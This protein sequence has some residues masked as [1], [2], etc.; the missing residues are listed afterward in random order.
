M[1]SPLQFLRRLVSRRGDQKQ[2]TDKAADAKPDLLAIAAPA[3][4]NDE[5]KPAAQPTRL[6]S[7]SQ[8]PSTT[9]SAE[10]AL[11]NE[12]QTESYATTHIVRSDASAVDASRSADDA[13]IAVTKAP[14]AE[15][16]A[17]AV[18]K[19]VRK[20]RSRDENAKLAMGAVQ[21]SHSAQQ[22][23]SEAISLDQEIKALRA[24]LI[25]KLQAQNAHLRKMLARFE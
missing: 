3:E 4:T 12:A 21:S 19:G 25:I 24:Q 18:G 8:D 14:D 17:L 5:D 1:A 15:Q 16:V 13:D 20:R 22:A 6:E 2:D 9:V 7:P 10:P 23:L 11:A